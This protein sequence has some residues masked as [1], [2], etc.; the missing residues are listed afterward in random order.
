MIDAESSLAFLKLLCHMV[1]RT[2]LRLA[3][4]PTWL[5]TPSQSHLLAAHCLPN[6]ER[7]DCPGLTPYIKAPGFKCHLYMTTPKCITSP[8]LFSDNNC[9]CDIST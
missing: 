7:L 4:P 8:E 6:Q 9:L 5:A 3:S 2:K 1:S